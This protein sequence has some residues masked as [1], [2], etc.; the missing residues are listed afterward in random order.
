[1]GSTVYRE[2]Y[3]SNIRGTL[4]VDIPIG[5]M[6]IPL[7]REEFEDNKNNQ[8]VLEE[9]DGLITQIIQEEK[10]NLPDITFGEYIQMEDSGNIKTDFCTFSSVD[11]YYA[12]YT[13]K[14]RLTFLDSK[15]DYNNGNYKFYMEDG[16]PV[17]FQIDSQTKGVFNR[18]VTRLS[19]F[20]GNLANSKKENIQYS[21][22]RFGYTLDP[23]NYSGC[24]V[25]NVKKM[26]LPKLET[27]PKKVKDKDEPI[28]YAIY[29]D[30]NYSSYYSADELEEHVATLVSIDLEDGWWKKVRNVDQL[31]YRTIGLRSSCGGHNTRYYKPWTCNTQK[32]VDLMLAKGWVEYGSLEYNE[33]KAIIQ[34]NNEL[35]R[36]VE[37]SKRY[38]QKWI[39]NHAIP[40]RVVSRIVKTGKN[41]YDKMIRALTRENSFRGRIINS[42]ENIY[43]KKGLTR[44]D[45]RKLLMMK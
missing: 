14:K 19:L 21:F 26:K 25:I 24:K 15:H 17:I 36:R 2:T 8:R 18:W 37:E 10:S 4:L 29:K 6:T 39:P 34:K 28:R 22:N 43:Y 31:N 7:S 32:M 9:I 41:P 11:V 42:L 35:E 13:N 40:E 30:G 12:H 3:S 38:I 23:A 44:E 33:A 45:F 27:E 20:M 5:K 16:M 1:M